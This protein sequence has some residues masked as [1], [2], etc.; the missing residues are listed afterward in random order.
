[1]KCKFIL[2]FCFVFIALIHVNVAKGQEV[3][4]VTAQK[5]NVRS[6]PTTKSQV[7]GSLYAKD[8]VDVY[9]IYNGWATI[10]YKER[11]GFVS[12]K[13]LKLKIEEDTTV[14]EKMADSVAVDT[15][16]VSQFENDKEE[17]QGEKQ[18]ISSS[19]GIDFVPSVFLGYANFSADGASP[20]GTIGGGVD[21]AF[22]FIAH[23]KILFFPKNYY[24]E[25]SLGYALKGSAAFPLHYIDLKLSPIGY[26]YDISD[27]T[28]FGKIGAYVGYTFSSIETEIYSFDTNIDVGI[29]CEVGVEYDKIGVGV[30]YE[31]SFTDACNSQLALKNQGF[32]LNLSYR[33]FS[34]K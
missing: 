30:S 20:K 31:R 21:F 11:D 8:E 26:M 16:T 27:F 33:L 32:Y 5:L 17:I 10:N 28:L 22:Q 6:R 4:E 18:P 15:F 9:K 1:M 12:A 2:K 7:I 23:D 14:I 19:L 29:L 13:Y 3:Y 25:A 24:M 34:L